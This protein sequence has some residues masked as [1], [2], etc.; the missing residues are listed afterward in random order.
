MGKEP[1]S[2]N[3]VILEDN[4]IWIH[5]FDFYVVGSTLYRWQANKPSNVN[6][7]VFRVFRVQTSGNIPIKFKMIWY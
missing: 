5:S 3:M 4:G 1:D 7:C 2:V 6:E